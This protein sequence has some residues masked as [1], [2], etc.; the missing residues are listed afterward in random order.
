MTTSERQQSVEIDNTRFIGAHVTIDGVQ[1]PIER[2]IGLAAVEKASQK[3]PRGILPETV[4]SMYRVASRN[5]GQL[6][7]EL[8]A[9]AKRLHNQREE[10]NRLAALSASKPSEPASAQTAPPNTVPSGSSAIQ[11]EDDDDESDS[12]RARRLAGQ[13]DD[14]QHQ[15]GRNANPGRT[16]R[17]DRGAAHDTR[18]L[19]PLDD[20]DSR[21]GDAERVGA[22]TATLQSEAE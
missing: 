11:G 17:D 21:Q 16:A 6:R 8:A 15:H 3:L 10:I 7:E 2:V 4:W 12:G 13:G 14:D 5:E 18:L 19:R 1:V 22:Q 20:G 9:C